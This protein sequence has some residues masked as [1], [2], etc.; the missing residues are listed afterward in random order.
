MGHATKSLPNFTVS[1][2]YN[3]ER[4]RSNQMKGSKMVMVALMMCCFLMV[5][6]VALV[7]LLA[8]GVLSQKQQHYQQAPPPP[9]TN[10]PPFQLVRDPRQDDKDVAKVMAG[11]LC[12]GAG[13]Q[14][15]QMAATGM[16][17]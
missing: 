10:P 9:R 5:F 4:H 12:V 11:A 13:A 7:G 1:Q 8:S 14:L 2:M 15:C 16:L 17:S 6:V 3:P